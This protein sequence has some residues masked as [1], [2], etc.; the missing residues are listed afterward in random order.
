[1]LATWQ[2][3]SQLHTTQSRLPST[4]VILRHLDYVNSL[5]QRFEARSENEGM[6]FGHSFCSF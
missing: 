3:L 1:M 5:R 6:I 2:L 4:S